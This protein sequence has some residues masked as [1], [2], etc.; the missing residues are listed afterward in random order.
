MSV[1]VALLCGVPL[2]YAKETPKQPAQESDAE[3]KPLEEFVHLVGG[4]ASRAFE[5]VVSAGASKFSLVG[6]SAKLSPSDVEK[7]K[8]NV[9]YRHADARLSEVAVW[10]D[11]KTDG[12]DAVRR[13]YNAIVAAGRLRLPDPAER[14]PK[15]LKV[16]ITRPGHPVVTALLDGPEAKKEWRVLFRV[17]TDEEP[18]RPSGATEGPGKDE[19]P[20]KKGV[21]PLVV[22][23]VPLPFGGPSTEL[24]GTLD[25]HNIKPWA[26]SAPKVPL[27]I[28]EG[29]SVIQDG[30]YCRFTPEGTVRYVTG[31]YGEGGTGTKSDPQKVSRLFKRIVGMGKDT[32]K[33]EDSPY[34]RLYET[35]ISRP[36]G[37]PL[38]ARVASEHFPTEKGKD[39]VEFTVMLRK[40][41]SGSEKRTKKPEGKRE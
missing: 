2:G 20:G 34:F 38:T 10:L 19:T 26:L 15:K 33:K 37:R 41:P 6:I 36:G 5:F 17:V 21:P 3:A 29:Q 1:L 22:G 32:I 14:G 28:G 11:P 18:G 39:H 27:G 25:K 24:L 16:V 23:G 30:I 13:M 40:D 7:H 12:R 35:T 31:A 4:K 8:P 9:L